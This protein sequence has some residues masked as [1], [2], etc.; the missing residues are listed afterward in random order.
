MSAAPDPLA[1]FVDM[2][3][4]AVAEKLRAAPAGPTHYHA[5]Q[6]PPF[7]TRRAL[8]DAIRAGHVTAAKIGRR[9]LV[10]RAEWERYVA[11][12]AA[13]RPANDSPARDPVA[14][15]VAAFRARV[16]R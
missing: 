4:C 8:A 9:Q 3:A 16:G 7:T 10:E 14:A 5:G 15:S 13:R 11:S 6:L 2:L 12:R 1:A